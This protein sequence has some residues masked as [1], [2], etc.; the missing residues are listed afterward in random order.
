MKI[1]FIGN[2]QLEVIGQL[3]DANRSVS[4]FR[5]MEV[6]WNTPPYKLGEQDV[7]DLFSALEESDVIFGQYYSDKWGSFSTANLKKYFPNIVVLPTLESDVSYPQLGY[8]SSEAVKVPPAYVYIDYRFLHLYLDRVECL[9]AAGLYT[10]IK[11]SLHKIMV[12]IDTGAERYRQLYAS[13][14]VAEDYSEAYAKSMLINV[15]SYYTVS[16]PNNEN[17]GCLMHYVL[18][19]ISPGLSIKLAG[20]ELLRNFVVPEL[21]S[22][23]REYFMMKPCSLNLAAKLYYNLFTGFERSFLEDEL[24]KSNYFRLLSSP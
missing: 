13:G 4:C 18:K 16:H 11:P 20:P 1:S 3:I 10:N 6:R 19:H 14:A 17:L 22:A 12:A 8:W 9:A 5:D 21:G 2:C 15:N 23:E 7:V 24:S